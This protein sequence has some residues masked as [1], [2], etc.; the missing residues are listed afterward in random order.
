[1]RINAICESF[2]GTLEAE[3]LSRKHVAPHE[4][5]RR[6]IVSFLEGCHNALR[7]HGSIGYCSPLEFE[8]RYAQIRCHRC[9][10]CPQAGSA[11]VMTG[12]PPPANGQPAIH[13][14]W[15]VSHRI[16][17]KPRSVRR[18]GA[19]AVV[20][21]RSAGLSPLFCFTLQLKPE[22]M[23]DGCARVRL[24]AMM[25]D[26]LVDCLFKRRRTRTRTA[27]RRHQLRP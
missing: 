11:V 16:K 21:T 15:M 5:V 14:R 23:V 9:A 6:R 2:F 8:D 19:P 1:M 13:P 18:N 17:L 12:D 20:A 4:Q 10:G 22:G 3:L 7:L 26:P 27:A 24:Q 25:P